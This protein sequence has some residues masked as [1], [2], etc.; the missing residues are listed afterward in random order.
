MRK[1]EAV[2]RFTTGKLN[3]K[4]NK[5]W[6]RDAKHGKWKKTYETTL[7]VSAPLGAPRPLKQVYFL[8]CGKYG[9]KCNKNMTVSISNT[10]YFYLNGCSLNLNFREC[11]RQKAHKKEKNN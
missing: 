6:A 2:D 3:L 9:K 1:N 5:E 7:T 8:H 10:G 11:I 4:C